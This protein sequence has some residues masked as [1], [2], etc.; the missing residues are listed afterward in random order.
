M[1]TAAAHQKLETSSTKVLLKTVTPQSNVAVGLAV[2]HVLAFASSEGGEE[3]AVRSD[4]V[5]CGQS[6]R[7][8]GLSLPSTDVASTPYAS[9]YDAPSIH[10]TQAIYHHQRPDEL[11]LPV[12]VKLR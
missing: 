10:P 3:R 12:G 1:A 9:A 8:E 11:I 5:V 6:E 2:E 4:A 7:S